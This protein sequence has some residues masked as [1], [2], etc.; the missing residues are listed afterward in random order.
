MHMRKV[1][2]HPDLFECRDARIPVVF[3]KIQTGVQP[4]L[5]LS[6]SPDVRA[7]NE[8]PIIYNMPKL[9]FDELMLITDNTASTYRKLIPYEDIAF[10]N[11]ST[12]AH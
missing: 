6:N 10:S 2:N 5:L 3:K 7:Q 8:N 11:I 1:C 9:V 12:R 4:N